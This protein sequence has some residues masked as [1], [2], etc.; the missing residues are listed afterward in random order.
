MVSTSDDFFKNLAGS[1]TLTGSMGST[2][3]RQKVDARWVIQGIFLQVHFMQE[4]LAPQDQPP[5]EAIYIIGY[6]SQ[7]EDYTMHLFDTFGTRYARTIGVG[8]RRDDSVEFLFEYPDGLLSNT[9][10]WNRETDEWEML[11]RQKEESG[12]WK[13][14]ARKSLTRSRV[15]DR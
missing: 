6:D 15:E 14:F 10:T 4:I 3:L 5:Y 13:I 8:T 7:S 12:E 11:L 9:F 1:W 2:E